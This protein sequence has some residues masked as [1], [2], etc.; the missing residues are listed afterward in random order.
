MLSQWRR[1]L[2][3]QAVLQLK[4]TSVNPE[5][6]QAQGQ[7]FHSVDS[8]STGDVELHTLLAF[9]GSADLERT[10]LLVALS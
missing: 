10:M 3:L 9:D 7:Q 2:H 6:A 5:H 8:L 1:A 4:L